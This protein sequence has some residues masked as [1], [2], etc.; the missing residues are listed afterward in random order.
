[1]GMSFRKQKKAAALFA[2]RPRVIGS[3]KLTGVRS[4]VGWANDLLSQRSGEECAQDSGASKISPFSFERVKFF[5]EA[6]FWGPII[7]LLGQ[8]LRLSA[9]P[10]TSVFFARRISHAVRQKPF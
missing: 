2:L 6:F 3:V 10:S 7:T 9:G 1:M 5:G 8:A 4:E